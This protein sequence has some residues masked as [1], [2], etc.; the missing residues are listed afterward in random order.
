MR[1]F[2]DADLIQGK[3]G[4]AGT[5]GAG[6]VDTALLTLD[7]PTTEGSTLLVVMKTS[8]LTPD[9]GQGW[10]QN[11]AETTALGLMV[12]SRADVPAGETSWTW[13]STAAAQVWT[14]RIEEWANVAWVPLETSAAHYEGANPT[15][16]ATGNSGA[17]ATQYVMGIA[18]FTLMRGTAGAGG[19]AAITSPQIGGHAATP[20]TTIDDGDGT[21][22]GDIRLAVARYYG[23]EN[24][25]GP[26]SA[27]ATASGATTNYSGQSILA[28]YRAAPEI[29]VPADV[30]VLG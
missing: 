29:I 13:T 5:S 2:S 1:A 22:S 11:V 25:V 9:T 23:T 26:W 19:F 18:G 4:T 8:A 21:A 6:V 7:S 12:Y 16:W 24:D 17:I 14:W 10:D 28:V 20:V 3:D 15:A 30:G 27:T